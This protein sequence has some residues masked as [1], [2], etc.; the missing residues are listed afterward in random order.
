MYPR[1]PY[2]GELLQVR[3]GTTG[4]G[5]F[6]TWH[7]RT[8]EVTHLASNERW[9]FQCHN[10]IDKKTNWQ[11]VLIAERA[12]P[13]GPGVQVAVGPA[14]APVMTSPGGPGMMSLA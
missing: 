11:R 3:C 9:V 8:V 12:A 5:L 4:Q 7:L 10:W 14:V 2:L 1:L 6:A 13:G